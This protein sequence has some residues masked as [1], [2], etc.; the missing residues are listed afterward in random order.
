MQTPGLVVFWLVAALSNGD[1][2]CPEVKVV[3]VGSSD[4]LT[5]LRGCPGAAGV[6]G[7]KG[8]AGASGEKGQ[9]GSKGEPGKAGPQGQQGQKGDKGDGGAPEQFYAARNCKELLDQGAILSG[10][11]KIYP[12]G[13]RPLTVLC[14]MDTDG[15]G[16]IVFQ[17]RWDGSVDFFRDWDSYKKGFGSQL[18]EFWLG[19]DNI[20]TLTSAGT[21]KL[22]IDFTDFENQNSFAAYDSFATLGEKDNYKLILGAYSGG[23]AGDSLNHHRNCPFS[24]KDRDNDFHNINCADTFKG[25]WWYGSC[26]DS[27]LNGLYL[28]GKHS[29]EALGINWETGKGNGYSYKVTEMKFRPK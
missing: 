17:R 8:E 13:E 4:K 16:W 7:Y 11:Y 20:H 27:N 18:S 24:T 2:S 26:H 22:R 19:N 6:P 12:D 28:R 23:T 3:G 5:I 10:W 21:Y 14:D 29:N 1:D 25:G 9:S 15:G